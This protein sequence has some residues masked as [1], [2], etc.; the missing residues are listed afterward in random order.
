MGADIF[1]QWIREILLREFKVNITLSLF[2]LVPVLFLIY[3]NYLPCNLSSKLYLCADD[4]TAIIKAN[5]VGILQNS[6]NSTFADLYEWFRANSLKH[7]CSKTQLIHLKMYDNRDNS[8]LKVN[9]GGKVINLI[10]S[11]K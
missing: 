2:H 7:N 5:T 3:V 1:G 9:I 11:T 8:V 10:N 6:L 4:T